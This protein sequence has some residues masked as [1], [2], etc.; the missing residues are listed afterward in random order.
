[1]LKIY[2]FIPFAE[3]SA[4]KLGHLPK[5]IQPFDTMI[6]KMR[7]LCSENITHNPLKAKSENLNLI[8]SNQNVELFSSMTEADKRFYLYHVPFMFATKGTFQVIKYIYHMLTDIDISFDI[9]HAKCFDVYDNETSFSYDPDNTFANQYI[10][11]QNDCLAY[12][13]DPDYEETYVNV[14]FSSEPSADQKEV[15]KYIWQL[16]MPPIKIIV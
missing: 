4:D 16:Y 9:H 10:N 6:D 13:Y 1:M 7:L 15:L 12:C 11:T 8:A 14:E 3:K 2:D 5:F